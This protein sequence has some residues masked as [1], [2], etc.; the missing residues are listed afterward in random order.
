MN[1][2]SP[3]AIVTGAAHRLG[4]VF[5]HTLAK[6]GY[7]I[8]LHYNNAADEA[9]STAAELRSLGVDVILAEANLAD[10]DSTQGLFA[11]VDSSPHP[12]RV[13]VN[14]AA[15]MQRADAR[16][17]TIA[18]WDATMNLN[19]RAPFILA[20]Q[21]QSR[22]S[23]AGGGLIVNI[24]DV[25]AEKAWSGFPTY[26]V[27]KAAL[28]SLTKILARSFAPEVR[29]NAIAPGLVLPADDFPPEEWKRLINRLPLKRP[30]SMD[31]IASALEFLLKNEYMTGQT[32]TVGGGYSLL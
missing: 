4:R 18:D 1:S 21:A 5:A 20:Q 16:E 17:L 30:A 2:S 25:A 9:E 19:L 29:V 10:A 14:S 23:A 26:T 27:S 8:F 15:T 31:E 22:M 28:Q 12:L 3:L 11:L 6:Q 7:A 13:L 24:T 32:I